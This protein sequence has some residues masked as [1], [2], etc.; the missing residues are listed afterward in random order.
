MLPRV[1]QKEPLMK[2]LVAHSFEYTETQIQ[3]CLD[4]VCHNYFPEE[5]FTTTSRDAGAYQS[6]CLQDSRGSPQSSLR[7]THMRNMWIL[8]YISIHAFMTQYSDTRTSFLYRPAF[9][10]S[11]LPDETLQPSKTKSTNQQLLQR[12]HD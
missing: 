1:F 12:T 4:I 3:K 8:T 6:S 2:V 7:N 10:E 5:A 9:T 11:F